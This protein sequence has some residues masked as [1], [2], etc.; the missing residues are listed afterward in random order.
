[1]FE[2]RWHCWKARRVRGKTGRVTEA[3]AIG[4]YLPTKTAT[5]GSGDDDDD[6]GNA[7]DVGEGV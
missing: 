4:K 1:M 6:A 7:D 2:F 3:A 5:K